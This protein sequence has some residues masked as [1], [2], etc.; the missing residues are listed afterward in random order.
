MTELG[1][2]SEDAD[3]LMEEQVE[4]VLEIVAEPCEDDREIVGRE[5]VVGVAY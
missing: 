1:V 5:L 3:E 4:E 2:S